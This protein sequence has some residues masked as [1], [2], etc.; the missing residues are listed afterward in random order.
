MA[1]AAVVVVVCDALYACACI[2]FP[3][4]K[5]KVMPDQHGLGFL[6]SLFEIIGYEAIQ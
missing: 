3:L 2:T 4:K 6:Q 5:K 1:V